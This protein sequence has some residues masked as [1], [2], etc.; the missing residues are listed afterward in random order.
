MTFPPH[1]YRVSR[2]Q[3]NAAACA[4][5]P[6]PK[7]QERS[8]KTRTKEF[9]LC[10]PWKVIIMYLDLFYRSELLL[11]IRLQRDKRMPQLVQSALLQNCKKGHRNSTNWDLGNQT[12]L[13]TIMDLDIFSWTVLLIIRRQDNAMACQRFSRIARKVREDQFFKLRTIL[14]NISIWYILW[15]LTFYLYQYWVSRRKANVQSTLLQNCKKK[16]HR[17]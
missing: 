5:N 9:K 17:W 7:L 14:L 16:G 1:Q 6:F 15:I 3:A 11:N 2:R 13:I 12:S 10:S 4:V 8:K